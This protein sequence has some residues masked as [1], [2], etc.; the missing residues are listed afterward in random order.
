[1][2]TNTVTKVHLIFKTHLDVGF[3]DFARTVVDNYFSAYIPKAIELA[4]ML[5]ERGRAERFVWTTGSWLIYEYLEQASSREREKMDEAI[6]N[7]DITWHGLPFTT[8]SEAMGPSLFRFGLSL[9]KSLD[10]RYGKTTIAAKMTDVPGHTRA[11]VPLLAEAGIRF[12][13]IGVNPACCPPDVPPVFVWRDPTGAEVL[14]MYH[15]GT[16]GS[17]MTVPGLSEAIAVEHTGDN[18]GPQTLGSVIQTFRQMREQFPEAQV[19]ASTLDA[20]AQALLEIQ[21]Q[22]PVVTH[23]IG[24]TWIHGVGT[25]PTKM[26]QFRALC[27]LRTAWMANG[28]LPQDDARF[29]AFSR[30]LLLIPEHTWGLDEKNTLADYVNYARPDFERARQ[31]NTPCK[32]APEDCRPFLAQRTPNRPSGFRNFEA[33][34]AEQRG[35]LLAALKALGQSPWEMKH[36]MCW[37]R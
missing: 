4:L 15:K 29:S 17:L 32:E 28:R 27:R 6:A 37:R 8:H 22:L 9:A 31:A 23:E 33:S 35:Y 21:P 16:Y 10:A 14:V 18:H 13:H 2:I 24:D 30:A 7:G 12:L 25:D 5:R 11:I 26:S 3:T 19:V 36:A 20:Y 34:W 1:M